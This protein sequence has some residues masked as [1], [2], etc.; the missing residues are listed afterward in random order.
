MIKVFTIKTNRIKNV[1]DIIYHEKFREAK[2][3]VNG[4][5]AVAINDLSKGLVVE[6]HQS[7]NSDK[8]ETYKIDVGFHPSP[9]GQPFRV[10]YKPCYRLESLSKTEQEKVVKEMIAHLQVTQIDY[11][12]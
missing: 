5:M 7:H 8:Y 12:F 11:M 9:E 6:K 1:N 10:D 4:I 3:L 2:S